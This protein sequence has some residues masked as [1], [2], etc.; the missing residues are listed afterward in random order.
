MNSVPALA[1][2][3]TGL[4]ASGKSTVTNE[5]ASQLRRAGI[6]PAVLE[7]DAFRAILTPEPTYA[8][9]ERDRFYQQLADIGALIT[10][11]GISVIFDATANRRAYRNRARA[12]IPRF[13]EVFV[14]AP[15]DICRSRDPKGIY[16]AADSSGAVNVPGVQAP[17]EPP[18]T[19]DL[20]L[21][22]TAAPDHNA[23]R[24]MARLREAGWI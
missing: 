7:S 24:I 17:Y 14:D 10:Q 11:Q 9:D 4:P 18:L 21:D 16:R 13:L 6:V 2:W 23:T 3:I 15:L 22:G 12:F 20:T 1:I 8:P 5:L 19:P